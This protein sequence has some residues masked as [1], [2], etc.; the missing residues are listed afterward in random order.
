MYKI[1]ILGN[2]IKIETGQ[3]LGIDPANVDYQA[4]LAWLDEGNTPQPYV[5]PAVDPAAQAK[6][7]LAESDSDMAR[8]V[9]DLINVM[10]T[11]DLITESDI[12]APA[13][14]KMDRRA[15]LRARLA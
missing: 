5:P 15:K 10:L 9:E 1:D 3:T 4:Y 6:A 2:I 11:K 12:P 8:I 13:R 14:D 7:E